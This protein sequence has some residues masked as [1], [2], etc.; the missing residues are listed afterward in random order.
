MPSGPLVRNW[1]QQETAL[2][3]VLAVSS[4]R[5]RL[6]EEYAGARG[7]TARGKSQT[8]PRVDLQPGEAANV[9]RDAR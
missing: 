9:K 2:Y 8:R 6:A 3:F 1:I 5:E 7:A 4:E